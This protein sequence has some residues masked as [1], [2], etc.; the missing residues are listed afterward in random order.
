[1]SYLPTLADLW[2]GRYYI[3][4]P[5][6][7]YTHATASGLIPFDSSRPADSND[8]LPNPIRLLAVELS[9]TLYFCSP[10]K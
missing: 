4:E 1:M 8:P 9:S 7:S 2:L 6:D 10:R 5:A 3:F